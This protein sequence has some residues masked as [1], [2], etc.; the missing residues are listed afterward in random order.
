MYAPDFDGP[1]KE[2][3][4]TDVPFMI[5]FSVIIV[6]W[7]TMGIWGKAKREAIDK[8]DIEWTI[9]VYSFCKRR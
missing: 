5:I 7:M 8:S 9:D 3:T 4:Y 1:K 6:S 2:R